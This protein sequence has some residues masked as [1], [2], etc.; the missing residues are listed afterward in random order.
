MSAQGAVRGTLYATDLTATSVSGTPGTTTYGINSTSQNRKLPSGW[1]GAGASLTSVDA[2]VGDHLVFDIG[3]RYTNTVTTSYTYTL[4]HGVF[5]T[6]LPEDET[7]TSTT[8][9]P[10]IEFSQTLVFAHYIPTPAQLVMTDVSRGVL[11]AAVPT[12]GQTWPRG[13]GSC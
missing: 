7:E 10:W 11:G 13:V 1:S 8:M 12:V 4:Q 5:D 2:Q 3:V 9:T 6:E